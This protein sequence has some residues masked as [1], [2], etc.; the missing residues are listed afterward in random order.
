MSIAPVWLSYL[1]ARTAAEPTRKPPVARSRKRPKP[2]RSATS[3]ATS[4]AATEPF[5]SDPSLGWRIR[6]Y[7]EA[8][9]ITERSQ[10]LFVDEAELV[11]QLYKLNLS[12]LCVGLMQRHLKT[13]RRVNATN[14]STTTTTTTTP[15]T[16]ASPAGRSSSS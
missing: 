4:I 12:L 16:A 1:A 8:L 11:T 9:S 5:A 13:P 10:V 3:S 2:T 14:G 6:A 7:W 15:T